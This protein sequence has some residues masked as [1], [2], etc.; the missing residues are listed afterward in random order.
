MSPQRPGDHLG[1]QC[2]LPGGGD[3]LGAVPPELA[4][5]VVDD[6]WQGGAGDAD[7]EV[8][9]WRDEGRI[10]APLDERDGE[11]FQFRAALGWF[12]A[13]CCELVPRV[14]FRVSLVT[15]GFVFRQETPGVVRVY[16]YGECQRPGYCDVRWYGAYPPGTV[17]EVARSRSSGVRRRA[18]WVS[19]AVNTRATPWWMNQVGAM[20]RAR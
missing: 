7:G 9:G 3:G 1:G 5:G 15:C 12:A 20:A 4:A 13:R 18:R 19:S 16:R 8:G 2:G 10:V 17:V 6:L 11:L 14:H